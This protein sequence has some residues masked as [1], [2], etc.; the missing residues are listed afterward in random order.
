MALE[1]LLQFPHFIVMLVGFIHL[2]IALILVIVHKPKKWFSLHVIFATSGIELIVIGILIL[3]DLT[4]DIPHAILGIIVTVVLLGELVGG[5]VARK[6]KDKNI[7]LAHI[8][9]S[10][11]IYI[12][13]LVV[14][15]LGINNF[16]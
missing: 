9:I 11:I 16:I 15:I 5:V 4:L 7:R 1:D 10:R 3:I 14:I 8:W 12:I 2:T 6:L 13:T